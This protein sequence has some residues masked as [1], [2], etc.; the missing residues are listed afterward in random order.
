MTKIP[1][2]GGKSR[3]L[4]FEEARTL[5]VDV[6]NARVLINS[7]LDD[8][9]HKVMRTLLHVLNMSDKEPQQNAAHQDWVLSD[10]MEEKPFDD[11]Y[12]VVGKLPEYFITAWMRDKMA[13]LDGVFWAQLKTTMGKDAVRILLAR[14][15]GLDACMST[16]DLT[17]HETKI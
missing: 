15:T 8:H 3:K 1:K 7:H 4:R 5:A 13:E 6:S 10:L 14:V 16:M 11:T 12:H 17:R 2:T 9:P